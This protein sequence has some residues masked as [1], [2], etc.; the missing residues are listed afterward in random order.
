MKFGQNKFHS[1]A[2][3]ELKF[4]CAIMDAV[5]TERMKSLEKVSLS[6]TKCVT[7]SLAKDTDTQTKERLCLKRSDDFHKHK[8]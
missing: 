7:A 4:S 3:L 8:H 1:E 5:L 6:H 2:D